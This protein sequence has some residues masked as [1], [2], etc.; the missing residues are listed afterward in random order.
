MSNIKSFGPKQNSH[1][2][3]GYFYPKNPDKYRGPKPIIYR[4]GLE[5]KFCNICDLNPNIKY[6]SSEPFS[7]SYFNP[8]DKKWHNYYVDFYVEVE[9]VDDNGEKQNKKFLLEVKP[10]NN[11]K[12]PNKPKK[13]SQKSYNNYTKKY[14]EFIVNWSKSKAAKEYAEKNNID[15]K[16]VTEKTINNWGSFK[17]V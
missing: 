3:Q 16:F 13:V 9:Y 11:L 4:S 14:S 6:W 5:Q 15:Y 10:E 12:K 2:K 7:I 8:L 1:F 17:N